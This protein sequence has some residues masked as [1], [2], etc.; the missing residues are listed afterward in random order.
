M[1]LTYLVDPLLCPKCGGEMRFLA[2]IEEAPPIEKIRRHI[3]AWDPVPPA[4]GLPDDEHDWPEGS[5]IP[6]T[7][8]PGPDIA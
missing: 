5:Q 1:K 4:T 8:G 3:D 2:V 7:Y 6:I